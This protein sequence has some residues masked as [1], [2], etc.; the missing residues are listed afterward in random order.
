MLTAVK[1]LLLASGVEDCAARPSPVGVS[2]IATNLL[3]RGDSRRAQRDIRA[4]GHASDAQ[5]GGAQEPDPLRLLGA[6]L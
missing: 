3:G 6:P 1:T 4:G 2:R 5:F